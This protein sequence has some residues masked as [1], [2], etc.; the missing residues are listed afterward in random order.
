MPNSLWLPRF[1]PALP[2]IFT[3]TFAVEARVKGPLT[4]LSVAVKDLFDV[5]G[6]VRLASQASRRFEPPA[7]TH[8]A[9]VDRFVRAGAKLIGHTVSTQCAF[10]GVGQNPDF[11]EPRSLWSP[12]LQPRL[13]GGS[14]RGGA[15]AVAAGLA[16]I[17]LGTD[18]GGS[19]RIPAACNGIYGIKFTAKAVPLTGCQP[20]AQS[21]DSVGVMTAHW[22]LLERAA[23]T[24]LQQTAKTAPKQLSFVV[25][26][27]CLTSLE[28][29]V[30]EHFEWV[31]SAIRAEGHSVEVHQCE[32]ESI[33]AALREL[34]SL[35]TLEAYKNY[36][37]GVYAGA[38]DPLVLGRLRKAVRMGTGT[39]DQIHQVRQHL[40]TTFN[41]E[42]SG[43]YLLLPTLPM[44]PPTLDFL[45]TEEGFNEMNARLLDLPSSVNAVDGCAI[46]I[47]LSNALPVSA[48]VA[49]PGG[50][51]A[52]LLGV[53]RV[54]SAIVDQ[55]TD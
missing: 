28:P 38:N 9:A 33:L 53:G 26:E 16:D 27:F 13:A 50:Q 34:P 20:L 25:P 1:Q 35:A 17:A 21:L 5:M 55:Q 46:S 7:K 15:L 6:Q 40:I 37:N 32:F 14:T 2:D 43:K 45:E 54:L 52:A 24:L 3:A 12:D 44:L 11:G 22:H 29:E 41:K 18:T 19:C 48:T 36:R 31:Q 23:E 10:S 4:G 47:P 39:L 30:A 49:A 42:F 51:D 8:A